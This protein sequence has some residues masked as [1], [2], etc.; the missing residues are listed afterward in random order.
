MRGTQTA[1]QTTSVRY[2][3]RNI[4]AIALLLFFTA[5]ALIALF[6]LVTLNP[7]DSQTSSFV[8]I[9]GTPTCLPHK[10]SSGAATLECALGLKGDDG[11]YYA[12]TDA[13]SSLWSE[14]FSSRVKIRGILA[15][16]DSSSQYAI[17]GSLAVS[18]V[19]KQ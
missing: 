7:P 18:S 3:R 10:N 4:I 2:P 14:D 13:P 6:N 15:E 12:L 11:R 17:S 9:T 8:T 16:P 5:V 1:H 19:S